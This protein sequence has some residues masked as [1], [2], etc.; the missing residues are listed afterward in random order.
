VV[1]NESGL[2]DV[3]YLQPG[4]YTLSASAPGFKTYERKDLQVRVG[5]QLA[6]DIPFEVG[7]TSE[8]ITVSGQA[9]LL[10]SSTASV[11]RVVDSQRILDLPLPG[12]NALSLARL[13]PGVVNLAAPSHPSL[14]PAVEVMS[15]LTVNGVRSGNVEFTVDGTP[16][17]W[18]TNAAYAPPTEMVAEFKVQTATYDASIGRSPGGNVNV[19]LRSGANQPHMALYMFHNNQHLQTLDLFQRQ[20]L[21]NPT[22]GPVTD[23]KIAGVNPRNI[24]NRFGATFSGP[25]VL[26][27]V[28]NGRNRTFWIFS[29]EGLTRPGVE[30]GNT[31][32]TVPTAAQRQ[33]NFSDLLNLGSIYQIF[34]PMT[35]VPAGNGRYTRQPLAG[36]VVPQS[37]IDKTALGLLPN[38]PQ[39]N[40][41]GTS[42]GLNNYQH[43]PTSWNEY[44][45]YT[46]K[47]DHN[48]N[49][50]HRLFGRYS[51]WFQLFSSGQTFDNTV[52]GNDRYRYNYGGVLDDVYVISPT[53][54]NNVRVGFTRFEQSTYPLMRGFDLTAAGFSPRLAAA[55]DP[56]AYTFPN[57]N[58]AGYQQVGNG[59]VSRTFS[60]YFTASESVSWTRGSHMLRFGAEFRV[61]REH[62]YDFGNTVPTES[63]ASAWTGGPFDNSAAAPIGQ[64]LASFLF[65]LP[66]G[67]QINVNSSYADQSRT[68]GFYAQDDWRVSSRVT[69]NLGLRWDYDTPMTERYDRSVRAFDF[70]TASPIA[71]QAIAAYAKNPLPELPASQFK[72]NGGLT[73]AGV[74]G[75]PRALWDTSKRN[76]APRVGI[77]WTPRSSTV[78]RAGYG[79]FFVPLGAD[80]TNAIQSGYSLTTSLTAS[81]DNGQ[82][83]VASLANPFPNGW[84]SPSG[85]SQGLSTFLGRNVSFFRTALPNPYMQRWSLSVQQQLP[86][87]FL[88]D[89]SYLGNRGTRLAASRQYDPIPNSALST[90]PVR[91][92]AVNNFLSAQFPNPFYPLPGSNIAGTNVARSQLLRSFPEFTGITGNDPQGYS[93]YHSLQ[94]VLERRFRQ[95][96]TFQANYTWSKMM[97]ATGYLNAGDSA[98]EK[99]ISD[100][101]RTHR[102]ASSAIFELPFGKG[103]RYLASAPAVVRQT[104]GGWQLQLTNQLNV[105]S[106]IGFGNALLITDIR[107][108]PAGSAQTLD[109]WFNTSAFVRDSSQQLVSNVRQMSTRF[110]GVRNPGVNIWDI[111]AVKNFSIGDKWRVQFRAEAMNALNHSNM[112]APNTDPTSTLFGKVSSTVGFPRYI[113]FGLKVSY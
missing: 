87:L 27:K 109:Q 16:S 83:Y 37:R 90:S 102:F 106:P 34:D 113:H 8:S 53:M 38:W 86:K 2:Y 32:F 56:Q 41:P 6:I 111:S 103:K 67:G 29:F 112:A 79:I 54:V 99:V 39:P 77:A 62:A 46:S 101:D 71:A 85:S 7:Q 78:L 28:Y 60:N 61:Y 24:L 59:S 96:I 66:T 20:S 81:L 108:V 91:D 93:W 1:T 9:S 26:P 22:T 74:N 33:G 57:L 11:G 73:F 47:I 50:K 88:L 10:E 5:D 94:A 13:A 35:T 15:S 30:R 92:N 55:I 89:V 52:N 69:V 43:Y 12:G 48:F 76:F 75:Q 40:L 72:V 31:F 64:G 70:N 97:E 14:G 104:V 17:M 36:N 58:I 25:V 80:R 65:G 49:E 68:T 100:L 51:Q 95:G 44:R 63:F 4:V 110:S 107:N 42:N 82:T 105:G 21:Y 45:T 18:G 3:T 84:P 23:A 19:V 98:P